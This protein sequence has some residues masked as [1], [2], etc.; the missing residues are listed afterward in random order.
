MNGFM[1]YDFNIERIILAL[2]VTPHNSCKIHKNRP[3]HGLAMFIDGVADYIF[4]NGKTVRVQKNQIVYLPKNSNY[5]VTGTECNLCY[6]INFEIDEEVPF[7]SFTFKPKNAGSFIANFKSAEQLW[8]TK[9]HGMQMKCKAELYNILYAMQKEYLFSYL[10]KSKYDIIKPAVDYIH[11]KYTEE[12]LTITKLSDMCGITPEY[13][14]SIFK[15]FYGVSPICYINNLKIT[16]A[17]ELLETGEFS[18]TKSAI[19]SGYSDMSHFSREFK[20]Y[21]GLSPKEYAKGPHK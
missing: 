13:F 3:S 20:K 6:A 19:Q 17:K 7:E 12:L 1:N 9:Q 15:G 5:M 4:D 21:F 11:R 10:P 16:R 2:F 18:V 14:R 8:K